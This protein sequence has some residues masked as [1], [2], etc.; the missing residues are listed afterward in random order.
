MREEKYTELSVLSQLHEVQRLSKENQ[1]EREMGALNIHI[2]QTKTKIGKKYK[3]GNEAYR[4]NPS[5]TLF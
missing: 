2:N 3:E 4:T 1:R 5:T